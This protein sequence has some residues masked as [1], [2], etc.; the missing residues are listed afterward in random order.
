VNPEGTSSWTSDDA[1]DRAQAARWCLGCPVLD[2]CGAAAD[3][4]DERFGVFGGRDRTP[5]P[6]RPKP[7]KQT[8]RPGCEA[9]A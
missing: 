1:D 8:T 4:H 5:S 7:T 9:T 2:E 3:E 6:T